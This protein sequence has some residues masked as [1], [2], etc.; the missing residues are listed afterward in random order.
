MSKNIKEVDPF[1]K[2]DDL[3]E[4]QDKEAYAAENESKLDVEPKEKKE[5]TAK[6]PELKI[7]NQDSPKKRSTGKKVTQL[8][9]DIITGVLENL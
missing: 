3:F 1:Q 7:P 8:L 5:S 4:K 9:G 6:K 2:F